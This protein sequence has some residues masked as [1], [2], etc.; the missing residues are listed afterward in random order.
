MTAP[1][2]GEAVYL[3]EA[4]GLQLYRVGVDIGGTFT[5]WVMVDPTGNVSVVKTPT[6]EDA[7]RGVLE[8]LRQSGVPGR[9]L[10]S[11]AHGTTL[12]TNALIERR[13]PRIAMITTRGLG[14]VL[15]QTGRGAKEDVWDIYDE[16][17][18]PSHV[19][20]RD[21]FEVE[22]RTLSSGE[23]RTTLNEDDAR[24][25]SA[26]IRRLG[27]QTVAICFLHSYAN[28]SNELRMK[29]ILREEHPTA[30]VSTSHETSPRIQEYERFTT[31]ILN[32]G[33]VSIVSSYVRQLQ[34]A[35]RDSGYQHDVLIA[36]SGGGLMGVEPIE[37]VPVR[38]ANSGPA[39]GALAAAEFGR[40]AGYGNIIGLDIGGTST[41]VSVA[42]GGRVRTTQAW[43]VEWGHPIL[44]P[45]V[46]VITVGAG[47]GSIAWFDAGGKLRNGPRSTGS[48]PGPACYKKGGTEATNTDAHVV[49]GSLRPEAMLGG[50][51]DIDDSLSRDVLSNRI[52]RTLAL[53]VEEAADAVIAVAEAN[54]ADA[55]RLATVRRGLD[56]RDFVLVAFGGAGPLHGARVARD[57]HI[58]KTIVPRW[59][60][61]TSA[62]GCLLADIRHDLGTSLFYPDAS[63]ADPAELEATLAGFE[64][65]LGKTLG[66]E[67]VP[68]D[69]R[70]L[71]RSLDFC[72]AGQW[73]VLQIPVDGRVTTDTLRTAIEAFHA[74][75]LRRFNFSLEGRPVE[76]H[77]VNVT[78][79]GI[80]EKHH[81]KPVEA[82]GQASDAR[83]MGRKVYWREA[84]GWMDSDV[85]TRDL[86]LPGSSLQGPAVVEQLDST[87]LVPPGMR[88]TVD[89]YLSLIIDAGSS[90]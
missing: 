70:V 59:P 32:A 62:F 64:R 50:A 89:A 12:G 75:H 85:Y 66:R 2:V 51:M 11:F 27:I 39:V 31:T 29:D 73:R 25:V 3:A 26:I 71:E 7:F 81:T 90:Q 54:M 67:N 46:D 77:G 6:T 16:S 45:A 8:A 87:T 69:G 78:G 83:I 18:R 4:G 30:L 9:S 1:N 10:A 57:L 22:E 68:P 15:A 38:T 41:D 5:D 72:Y 80:T 33:L 47:G 61:L 21:R 65:Q 24:S 20:P 19:P 28:G 76:L 35:L 42:E 84:G 88:A 79:I 17:P 37:T 43:Q 48:T 13:L 34:G 55:I 74:M 44:F 86:L 49:L 36:Q 63:K 53:S 40:L 23:I 56:P 14:G 58:P 82:R 60:G 52:G